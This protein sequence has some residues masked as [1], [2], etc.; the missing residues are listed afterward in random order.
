[1]RV[2][3]IRYRERECIQNPVLRHYTISYLGGMTPPGGNGTRDHT[4]C[5]C[6]SSVKRLSWLSVS[7][8]EMPSTKSE[9]SMIN[10]SNLSSQRVV[11]V[12]IGLH[13]TIESCWYACRRSS[14]S[15]S[16][17]R[18]GGKKSIAKWREACTSDVSDHTRSIELAMAPN[19]V[20]G[21]VISFEYRNIDLSSLL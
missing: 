17:L 15:S 18:N 11:V 2:Q 6:L 21:F 9:A 13:T 20:K 10:M 12:G 1:M 3:Y 16:F 14:S 5:C 4:K 19:K 7:A 8:E